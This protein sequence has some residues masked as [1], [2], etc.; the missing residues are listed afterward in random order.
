[1]ARF[2]KR[3]LSHLVVCIGS[4]HKALTKRR[5]V[6]SFAY[7]LDPF[8]GRVELSGKKNFQPNFLIERDGRIILRIRLSVKNERLKEEIIAKHFLKYLHQEGER[9]RSFEILK[10]DKPWDFEIQSDSGLFNIEI[11]SIADN[12]RHF[13]WLNDQDKM[14]GLL[15]NKAPTER[16]FDI[17][18][19]HVNTE[20]RERIRKNFAEIGFGG[21]YILIGSHPGIQGTYEDMIFTAIQKK[22]LKPHSGKESTIILIENRT[23]GMNPEDILRLRANLGSKLRSL[24]FS[25]IWIYTGCYSDDDGNNS[26]FVLNK[27]K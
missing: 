2:V 7:Q 21:K 26:S 18:K 19:K 13:I 11:T 27:L 15:S 5:S 20:F 25:E 17:I 10:R 22:A 23:S 4:L 8:F 14:G 6:P 9:G 3:Y 24:P 16:D 1:M 12:E